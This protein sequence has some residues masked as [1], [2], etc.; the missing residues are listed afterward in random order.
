MLRVF[1]VLAAAMLNAVLLAGCD[2][3][4]VNATGEREL[5]PPR[6][7]VSVGSLY[8]VR[9]APTVSLASPA[10]L[11]SLCD[12]KLA[13]YGVAPSAADAVADIDLQKNLELSGALSGIQTTLVNA[14][15]SGSFGSYYDY[16]LTNAKRISI[17]Y[18]D[19]EKIYNAR[20]FRN[21]CSTWRGN[22]GGQN[23][24]IYQ[25][26][27]VTT[28]DIVFQRKSNL[29]DDGNLSVK[30]NS[31]EPAIKASIKR[32]AH[33]NYNGTGLVVTFG[34]IARNAAAN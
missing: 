34:P 18:N 6:A 2:Q 4:V 25:I 32:D 17:S 20:A 30:L 5:R 16:K 10:N 14:G 15:L 29:S 3:T 27:S 33:M 23:W 19:A 7:G 26:L 24:G 22:I 8:F 12:V 9:E 31:I 13:T 28:G 21:D 11:E 1:G